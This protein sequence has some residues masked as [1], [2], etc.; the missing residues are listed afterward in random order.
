MKRGK[1]VLITQ[2][3]KGGRTMRR[4]TK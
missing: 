4:F 2:A 3:R 1:P